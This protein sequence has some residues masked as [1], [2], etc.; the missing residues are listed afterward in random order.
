MGFEPQFQAPEARVLSRLDYKGK[1]IGKIVKETIYI[2]I[3]K[4]DK[5]R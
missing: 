3:P 4:K 5:K 2:L 1:P